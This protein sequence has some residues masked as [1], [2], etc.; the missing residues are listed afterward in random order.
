MKATIWIL[1]FL[2]IYSCKPSPK[3][4]STNITADS[5]DLSAQTIEASIDSDYEDVITYNQILDEYKLLYHNNIIIDT[6]FQ[7]KKEE[8]FRLRLEHSCLFD[9]LIIPAKYNWSADKEEFHTHNFSSKLYL[10][11]NNKDTILNTIIKKENFYPL[12]ESL[13]K[14]GVLLYPN[15]KG[16]NYEANKFT[17]QLQYSISVP[18]TDVGKTVYAN[19]DLKGKL[20]FEN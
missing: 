12:D 7:L 5:T 9:T 16:F 17:I 8:S 3:A 1:I 19:I 6:L 13:Q 20:S 4:D 11:K 2:F 18:L 14:Y 15:F 10:V